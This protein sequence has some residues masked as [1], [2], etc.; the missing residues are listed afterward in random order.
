MHKI[1]LVLLH[2]YEAISRVIT[3]IAVI[4]EESVSHGIERLPDPHGTATAN[5]GE[6]R[7]P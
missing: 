3:G 5:D 6:L 7:T 2:R 1:V 4:L